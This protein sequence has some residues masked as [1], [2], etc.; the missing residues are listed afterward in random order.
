MHL[1]VVILTAYQFPDYLSGAL[2]GCLG[3]GEVF[4]L[5]SNLN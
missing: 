1:V 2:I 5:V 4:C 3:H